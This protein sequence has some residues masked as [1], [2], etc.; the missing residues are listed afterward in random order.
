MQQAR[1]MLS[2]FDGSSPFDAAV[3]DAI[4]RALSGAVSYSVSPEATSKYFNEGVTKPAF[5]SFQENVAPQIKASFAGGN[6]FSSRRGDTV[7]RGLGDL[8]SNLSAQLAQA[9][10]GNMS[11]DAQLHENAANRQL[12]GVGLAEAFNQAPLT[13]SLALQSASAPFQQ[14]EQNLA[15]AKYQE[16]LRT[17]PENNPWNAMGLQYVGMPL[18]SGYLEQSAPKTSAFEWAQLGASLLGTAASAA[19]GIAGAAGAGGAGGTLGKLPTPSISNYANDP[20][21][22]LR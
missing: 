21:T 20:G 4:T 13:R 12:Q 6:M 2:Q 1:E 22:R 8:Q 15:T 7:Q 18:Q 10:M 5:K 19:T 16:W 3:S 11:L 9:Q 17:Q 14:H